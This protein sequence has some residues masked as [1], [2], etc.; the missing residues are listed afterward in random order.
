MGH[1]SE[2]ATPDNSDEESGDAFT[3]G[4]FG[5]S[6]DETVLELNDNKP[7]NI[8]VTE[9]F[10]VEVQQKLSNGSSSSNGFKEPAEELKVNGRNNSDHQPSDVENF[11]AIAADVTRDSHGDQNPSIVGIIGDQHCHVGI[12]DV[13]FF[14]EIS[15][16]LR[17]PY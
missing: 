3:D 13:F 5:E 9:T 7:S 16:L 17:F 2:M 10:N 12:H 11:S 6:D 8:S 14:R 1:R 15:V 4:D